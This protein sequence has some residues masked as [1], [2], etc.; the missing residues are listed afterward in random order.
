MSLWNTLRLALALVL[1]LPGAGCGSIDDPAGLALVT[2]DRFDFMACKEIIANR[3]NW[4]NKEK[5]LNGLI[6]KAESSP[7]GFIASAA[8]YRSELVQARALR[9][10]AEKAAREKGCDTPPKS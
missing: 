3:G 5:E 4:T 1:L 2:Q 7:G 10:A 8:A 9:A 6:E